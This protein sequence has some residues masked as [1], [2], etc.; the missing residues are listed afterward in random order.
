MIKAKKILI[1]LIVLCFSLSVRAI[2]NYDASFKVLL[3]M[4]KLIFEDDES[5]LLYINITNRSEAKKIFWIY[6]GYI[7]FRPVVYDMNGREAETLVDYR[8]QNKSINEVVKD[9]KPD[10]IN[11]SNNEIFTYIID[12]KTIYKIMPGTEYRVKALFFPDLDNDQSF[13][14]D[15]QLAFKNLAAVSEV[16]NSGISRIKRFS[17][18]VRALTPSEVV[19]LLLKAE[20]DRDWD[21]YFKFVNIEMLINAYPDYVKIYNNAVRKNDIEQKE[22]I[23]LEFVNF[24]KA[25]RSDYI[26]SYKIERELKRTENN[27]YVEALIKRFA[28]IN[29]SVYKYRYSLE[30]YENLWLITD[31]EVTVAK[32]QKI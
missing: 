9:V 1:I 14:S 3:S 10:I 32:G 28:S 16:K 21:N 12:L 4:E 22:K 15:N 2:E 31:V 26:I 20:K 7:S 8:L 17:S 30:K 11:L 25:E 18:P 29:P 5:I 19:L 23:I 24:L 27:I 13:I 6:D